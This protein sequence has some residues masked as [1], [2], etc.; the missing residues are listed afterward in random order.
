MRIVLSL[1]LM[2]GLAPVGQGAPEKPQPAKP[3]VPILTAGAVFRSALEQ[4][5]SACPERGYDVATP[6]TSLEAGLRH[7]KKTSAQP[8]LAMAERGGM[9]LLCD[10]RRAGRQDR[11]AGVHDLGIRHQAT[12]PARHHVGRLVI[13]DPTSCAAERLR[14]LV[15]PAARNVMS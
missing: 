12:R 1:V 13:P 9:V 4:V 8:I 11:C 3:A 7:L 15:G 2:T 6:V 10:L 5:T 14:S